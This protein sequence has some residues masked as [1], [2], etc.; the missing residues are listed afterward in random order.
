MN[1]N[2]HQIG[3][4][5][6]GSYGAIKKSIWY[7]LSLSLIT[8]FWW[9]GNKYLGWDRD[10]VNL[11]TFLSVEATIATSLVQRDQAHQEELIMKQLKYIKDILEAFRAANKTD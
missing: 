6:A 7:P 9:L 5:I 1:L 3:D 11:L 4:K 2:E 8:L 10:L